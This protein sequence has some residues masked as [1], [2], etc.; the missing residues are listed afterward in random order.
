VKLIFEQYIKIK[1]QIAKK[2]SCLIFTLIFLLTF[3]SQSFAAQDYGVGRIRSCSADDV[4]EVGGLQWNPTY[5]GKDVE[6]VLSNSTCIALIISSYVAVKAAITTMNYACGTGSAIPRVTPSLFHDLYDI[7]KASASGARTPSCIIATIAAGA[8]FAELLAKISVIYAIADEVFKGSKI[9]GANWMGSSIKTHDFSVPL[10]KQEVENQINAWM[11]DNNQTMLSFDN[12]TYREWFY[13]GVEIVDNPSSGPACLDPT[14][15]TIGGSRQY[16]RQRYY[17]RGLAAGNFNCQKYRIRDGQ[18]HP[19]PD[20]MAQAYECCIDRAKNFICIDYDAS[21]FET[22]TDVVVTGAIVGGSI[23][24]A[25]LTGGASIVAA[26]G[27]LG[28][29]GT[30]PT[31]LVNLDDRKVFCR[32]GSK[33]TIHSVVFEANYVDND[34]LICADTYSLCPYNFSIG[35]GTQYCNFYRDGKYED[36]RWQ[37]ITLQ[38]IEDGDCASKSEIRNPDCTLNDKAG[39]CENY[40]QYLVNCTQTSN[41]YIYNSSLNSPYFS[42]ACL[43]FIGDSQNKISFNGGIIIGSPRHFS[44]PIAQCVKE[45]MENVFYNRAGHTKC[46]NVNEYPSPDGTCPSGQYVTDGNFI[47]KVGNKVKEKS[48]FETIQTNM[49]FAVKLVLTFSIMLYGMNLLIGRAD[50]R[51]KK[52]SLSYLLKIGLVMYFATGQ[53]WQTMFF[54][55][56]YNASTEFSRMVFKIR[57]NVEESRRDGCQFG[58]IY[59]PDGSETV[60]DRL[61]PPGKEYLSMWDTLDCKIMRYLGYGPSVSSANVASLIFAGFLTGPVGLYLAFSVLIFGLLLVAATIRALHIFLSSCISIIIMVFVSPII[62]PL[63]LFAKTKDIFENWLKNLI[64]FTLQPMILFA[65]IAIFITVLDE[66]MLGSASYK[67]PGPYRTI[68]CQPRCI[69]V[70]EITVPYVNNQPPACDRIGDKIIEPMDDSVACLINFDDFGKF[71]GLEMFGLTIPILENLLSGNVK[72]KIL[73]LLKAA[74][75]MFILYKF[76]DEIPGITSALIG[77]TKLPT[78]STDGV[79]MFKKMMGTAKAIQKRVKRGLQKHGG[80]A[81]GAANRKVSDML[82]KGKNIG[83]INKKGGKDS[84]E[85]SKPPG[86]GGDSTGNSKKIDGADS[87]D[88][89]A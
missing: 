64:S 31:D 89:E 63:A 46:L 26:A 24:A 27:A 58:R 88:S 61:Y 40:C 13:N 9:C 59:L 69:D 25:P 30:D 86:G 57:T 28:G 12:K 37:M 67:G 52:E 72:G 55:G 45:T 53:A 75:I 78:A 85:K 22:V 41:P 60:S 19:D 71:P 56:V 62:I 2:I 54:D 11:R 29:T 32:A 21:A 38:D 10:Y 20:A 43:D 48:F 1:E 76:M 80:K 50:L 65:Y 49:K 81:M 84:T 68:D 79:A 23:L 74:L 3:F 4:S 82:N 83:P 5:G 77:G 16:P 34:R 51:N 18:S 44:A 73:T 14:A 70:N 7:G 15:A 47:Y 87:S 33:C 8:S 36:G 17:M 42:Q 66:S 35:G 39:K 6:F